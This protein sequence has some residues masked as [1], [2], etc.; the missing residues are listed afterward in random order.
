MSEWKNPSRE[1]MNEVL[2]GAFDI[3]THKETFIDYFEVIIT[4]EGQVLYAI[5]SHLE[6]LLE[7][8][9][10]MRGYTDR[11]I[12]CN[13]ILDSREIPIDFLTKNTGCISVWFYGYIGDANDVQTSKLRELRV[14]GVYRG[15]IKTNG[16]N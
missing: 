6:K 16:R 15:E 4:S 12:V 2:H 3:N 1:R 5:P 7:I 9:M 13:E 8:Y 14:A 11:N 10:D